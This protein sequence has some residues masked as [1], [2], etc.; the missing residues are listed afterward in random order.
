M[1]EGRGDQVACRINNAAQNEK[2]PSRYPVELL[3]GTIVRSSAR[4]Q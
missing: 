2:Q 1:Q 4:I 3:S